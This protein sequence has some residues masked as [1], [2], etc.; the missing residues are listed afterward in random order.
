M[1]KF[2]TIRGGLRLLGIR[3]TSTAPAASPSVRRLEYKPIKKVMV[4]NRGEIAI[5]VFRACTELGIRTVAV[6][7]EQDT[8]QMHRQKAD[9]AYLIGRGLAPVQAYLHIPDIIKVA[10]ENNVDAVHPGYGFLSE[11]ADF[12]QACQDAGVRFIGPSPEVVR[13]MG[14]KVE[15]RAIAIAAGVPVV[16]GTDAPITSLHEAHHFSNTYGFP[17]IFKA[18]YGGGGRGMRVV[19]SYEELEENYTR[20]YSEALAAFGNGALFVEKFIEKPRHIEVQ[21]LGD[22]YGN[23]LHLYERDCSIQRRHQKVVEI[24]PAAHLDPQLRSRLTSDSVKLAKQVG[25]EN[26][27]TVEFLVDKYGKHYFIEVNS[28]L[29]VEHTVTEEIT[30]VDLVHAQIHVAEGRSLPDL[31]LRQENIRINGCAIQCRVTTED[32]SRSFQPDTGRIEVFRSGEGM[33][34][35][36]DNASAFQGAVIS[37]HYDSL[38]VKVI[39]HGKD[40]PTAAT[41]MS[42]ALAEFR[43]RGVKTN[44]PFLQNV[45]N[46][47]QFLAGTVDTQFIDEN[48]ELFQLRPAQNRAQKLL[49]YLGH[50]MVNGPTTPIPVKASPSPTDPIVPVVPIGLP[51]AGFRDILLREGPEGFARA[52]RNHQGLLLMDTTF[53]DAHQS[54]LA[55]RV[56]THD[57]KKISPY[58]AHNFSKLF[59]IEN[60]G[61]AT[62]DVAMRFLYEC[63]WRRLQE[64]RELVPNIPFQMLL[65]GANAVGYTNYPDN[66]VFKFCEVAKENGMDV[67]RVFD[68][69]N[70]LPNLL[71]GMEAAGSAGG[72][73]EAAISYTGDVADPSRT[74]YS[75]QYYMGLAEELVRAGTHILC[76]KDMA[77]LLKPTACTMLVTSLRDRFPDLPLHIHT[78]DTSGAG[79]AAMLACAHAGADVVDVAADS[80]SGM[81]SQPSMGALVACTRGTP[82]DTALSASG[83]PAGVPLDRVFDYSEYWEGA[84]GLYA[85]FDCTATMKS[86]NSDVYENEIPGGQYTNL[87]F[88]AYSMGLGSKF[89]EVKKAYVEANQMLGDLIKVTP[90]SKIVGDLAQFMVQNGLSRAEA[91]AQ[92]E[93]LSFPRSVVEFLQGYIGVPH[94]GFPEPLRSKVLKDLPRVEGR[95]GASLPPLDLQALEKGLIERHGEEVTPEDVLSAAMYPDVFAHFKDFTA[96]FG[97]LDSLNT[98]LFLQGPKIA[99]EFEVELERGKTLHIKALAISD[100]NRAGQRQVFFELN[101]QLRSI[102][103]KDTQAM[104]EMHFHPKALKDVKGQIG[105]PMPGKVID[106]KVAA[107]D[108]VTK[109]QPLCV[110]SAMKM[111]TVVTSPVEG[112]VRKVHVTTDMTLEGD[113][114]ILEIE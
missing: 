29:Q 7:S 57:L 19:Q 67:F 46:N 72:V 91:E 96:T 38:L 49:H 60:W 22:Q 65:R 1:L 11:R 37:P 103:V 86:G 87:H 64:L 20:A 33:G 92:A 17:I 56:R 51:P 111:E 69:L 24:A 55:T 8:G 32:P 104:K 5:R 85:A 23:I 3:R 27:G 97:P 74:K 109:G 102:L 31:G 108:K 89:K 4:A 62:F 95:P 75:L 68:S 78:H 50:V 2:Q 94:G 10:K 44:I 35:R 90:S 26:A 18:A 41:K 21:I 79:V 28:R 53:R 13:K 42:R 88:Q 15:A 99:E 14:D 98:R 76:I 66:V 63:P 101:G 100:L 52:V 25:Y 43:V 107:G 106:I 40:H 58:V 12:A 71:L 59:S 16:P 70:Y 113:D 112:T 84:R 110:L 54:L 77:G 34:I 30:D 83:L 9:E 80:M 93:E 114:L 73:V 6:Y 81:T 36:L 105:A 48:P 61:G 39:A 45:L 47:Q 82:L